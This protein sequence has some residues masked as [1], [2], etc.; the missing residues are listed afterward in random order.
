VFATGEVSAFVLHR[1][2]HSFRLRRVCLWVTLGGL[3]AATFALSSAAPAQAIQRLPLCANNIDDDADRAIDFP[4]DSGCTNANDDEALDSTGFPICADGVDQDTD[5]KIDY[6]LDPGCVSAADT[7]EPDPSPLPQCSDGANNNDSDSK[8]DYPADPGCIAAS[9]P[10][11]QNVACSDGVDNDG[12]MRIDF[13]FDFGCGVPTN[14]PDVIDTSEVDP[15]QCNDGRDNDG[16]IKLDT[17]TNIAGQAADP[18]CSSPTDDDERDPPPPLCADTIDNDLDGSSD[19]PNDP[20]CASPLD[21]DESNPPPVGP[22]ARVYPPIAPFP[23]VRLRGRTD[24]RGVSIT[25]LRVQAPNGSRV[26]IYCGG[27]GCPTRRTRT[28]TRRGFVRAR[29]FERRLRAG[30]TLRIYV[31]KPGFTG[32]YTRFKIRSRRS[33]MRTDRCARSAGRKPV[34]CPMN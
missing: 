33:P 5:G 31:T 8:T 17:D 24:R 10:R 15:P 1:S 23:V 16:D 13:P 28:L 9:D 18:G 7:L 12:D 6:P 25:L 34:A 29:R 19:F 3:L 20:G 30:T 14:A 21:G 4:A 27:R 26:T 22:S 32:K 11:E 2:R